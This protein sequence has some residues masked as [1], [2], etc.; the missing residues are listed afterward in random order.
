MLTLSHYMLLI[1]MAKTDKII[2]ATTFNLLNTI[3]FE[4]N[5]VLKSK[6]ELF[7]HNDNTM[8]KIPKKDVKYLFKSGLFTKRVVENIH[9]VMG[10]TYKVIYEIYWESIMQMDHDIL[11]EI[12]AQK[13]LG[14]L[15]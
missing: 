2:I 10:R 15:N 13:A 9:P 8:L 1:Q 4:F 12:Q 7:G 11:K 6:H 3:S 14:T 5:Y